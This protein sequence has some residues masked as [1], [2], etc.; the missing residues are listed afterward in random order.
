MTKK[1]LNSI[2]FLILIFGVFAL[3]NQLDLDLP[4]IKASSYKDVYQKTNAKEW[5]AI[6]IGCLNQNTLETKKPTTNN[7]CMYWPWWENIMLPPK[8]HIPIWY[9]VFNWNER[10]IIN[11]LPV[12]NHESWFDPYAWDHPNNYNPYAR[13]YVQTLRKYHISLDVEEQLAW[14]K[15]RME[16]QKQ[17]Y[18]AGLNW[19]IDACG[20]YLNEYNH[21]DG[22]AAWE[23]WVMA[24]LYRWHYHANNWTWYARK[25]MVTRQYYYDYFAHNSIRTIRNY[26]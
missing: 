5:Q 19:R 3:T 2:L 15:D 10:A 23:D 24:C 21:R 6:I 13:G 22:F 4:K 20:K 12:I 11:R 1:L 16:H 8:K 18:V 17:R 7:N 9:K 26:K 25:L 14:M